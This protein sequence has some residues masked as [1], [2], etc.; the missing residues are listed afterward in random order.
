MEEESNRL[1]P[2]NVNMAN[3]K[4]EYARQ[5]EAATDYRLPIDNYVVVRVTPDQKQFNEFAKEHYLVRPNDKRYVF[6]ILHFLFLLNI[7]FL[8]AWI[9]ATSQR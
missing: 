5:Y 9:Y 8:D 7:I 4:F 1:K 6:W 2:S 3:S